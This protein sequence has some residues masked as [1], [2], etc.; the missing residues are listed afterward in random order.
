MARTLREFS[1]CRD[2]SCL[3]IFR[4]LDLMAQFVIPLVFKKTLDFSMCRDVSMSRDFSMSGHFSM[5][6]DF[7]MSRHFLMF[8]DFSVSRDFSRS[9]FNG[10]VCHSIDF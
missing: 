10:A 1:G 2:A 9:R 3:G 5:F 8:R 6:R 7:S 4:C